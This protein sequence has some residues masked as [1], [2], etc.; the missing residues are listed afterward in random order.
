MV[1]LH[2]DLQ[3]NHFLLSGIGRV[4]YAAQLLRL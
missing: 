1:E 3:R 2:S 4:K